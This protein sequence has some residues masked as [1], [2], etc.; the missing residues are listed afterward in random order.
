[1]RNVREMYCLLLERFVRIGLKIEQNKIVAL[2][3]IWFGVSGQHL[4]K[5]EAKQQI[6]IY[7]TAR[8]LSVLWHKINTVVTVNKRAT[9]QMKRSF[10]CTFVC[11]RSCIVLQS[12]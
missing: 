11:G 9:H 8:V 6:Y 10:D 1:M 3:L 12:A 2:S 4:K 5:K 7:K